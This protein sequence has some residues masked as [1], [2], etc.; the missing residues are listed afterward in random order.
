[1]AKDPKIFLLHILEAIVLIERYSRGKSQ[2]D[3]FDS[4]GFQDQVIRR[5][6]IIGEA[7][8]HI[9]EKIRKAHHQVPW[10]KIA[11]MRDKIVHEYFGIDLGVTWAVVKYDLPKLKKQIQRILSTLKKNG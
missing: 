5:I 10:K 9:P 1:M 3:F 6:E 7:A 4:V 2:G 11:G 8:R